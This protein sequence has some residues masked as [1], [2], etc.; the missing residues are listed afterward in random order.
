[1][2]A[3][4]ERPT[5]REPCRRSDASASRARS[6]VGARLVERG[7]R[8]DGIHEH[9]ELFPDDVAAR[10]PL[11][12]FP[13]T[14]RGGQTMR[15]AVYRRHGPAADVLV[16]EELDAPQP[17]PGEVRVRVA[18]SG[19]NPTDW[20]SRRGPGPGPVEGGF[21]VPNQDGAGVIDAV[22]PDVDPARVGERVWLYFAAWRR[23][24]GTAAEYTVVPSHRAV[25]LP[26]GVGFDLGASLG[27]P[28]MT[29]HR[30]LFADGP[31][32]GHT[33]LVAG[34]AGAVGHYA[35]ELAR[36]AGATVI[37]TVSSGE[38]A[39]LAAAAGAQHVVNYRDDDAARR[40]RQ[41]APAGVDRIVEV[42][43]AANLAL[44]LAVAAPDAS[45]V[46]YAA[47]Q[48][49]PS[50]PVRELM[51]RNLL[52]RFVLIY[53]VPEP[54]LRRAAGDITDA[55]AAGVLTELPAHRYPLED[56]AAAHDAVE[57]G[58]I[59]KVIVDVR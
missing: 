57:N 16:L 23:P 43:L 36:H 54:A 50:L 41:A 46:T 26:D 2:V 8:R 27:I 4:F 58:A 14:R 9:E 7:A 56:I 49:E 25:P 53:T 6:K 18:V 42:A 40:I 19:V 44:D 39:A 5:S 45:I 22:G 1:V 59:G 37:A 30:C 34:G 47:E 55:L 28:A 31:I 35:I 17:G 32:G 10:A 38:K 51:T 20:K 24:Y 12:S 11:A 15:A 21:Q 52:L 48:R 13:S 33:V 29:A 3:A